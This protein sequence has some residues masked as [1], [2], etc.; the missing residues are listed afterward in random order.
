MISHVCR[1][2]QSRIRHRKRAITSEHVAPDPIH[3]STH[4]NLSHQPAAPTASQPTHRAR[5]RRNRR[6]DETLRLEDCSWP[7]LD[8]AARQAGDKAWWPLGG[9]VDGAI[10]AHVALGARG[11]RGEEV[12]RSVGRVGSWQAG[13]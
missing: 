5:R 6:F 13:R 2:R 8:A 10:V 7:P 11:G 1:R 12:G 9:L 4:F 3:P